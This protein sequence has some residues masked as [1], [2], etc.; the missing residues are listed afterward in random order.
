MT[1]WTYLDYT[2]YGTTAATTVLDAYGLAGTFAAQS[3]INVAFILP[4]A[5]DPTPFLTSDWGARQGTLAAL[6]GSGTLWSIYGAS[7]TAYDALQVFLGGHGTVLGNAAGSDGYISS[8]ES[9]TVWATLTPAQFAAVFGAALL[10]SD[11]A[12]GFQYWNG[13]LNVPAG[14]AGVWFDTAPWYGPTP[15]AGNLAGNASVVPAQGPLSIGNELAPGGIQPGFLEANHYAGDIADWFYNFPLAGIEAPT[16]TVGLLEPLVGDAVAAGYSFQAGYNSFRVKAGISTPGQYYVVAPG[17]QSVTGDTGE[18]SLD[19][20]V[21]SSANPNS[22]LG[23]YVGSG[24]NGFAHSNVFTAYQSA[25]FDHIHAPP[26]LSS[27]FSIVPQSAPGSPFAYAVQQLFIDAA[28]ANMTVVVADNDWGSSW[29]FGNGLAN[30]AINVSSPYALLVG[31]TSLTP[32]SDAARD[33]SI[34]S[35]PTL[36]DSLLSKAMAGDLATVWLLIEGGLTRLP[37]AV[38]PEAAP[39]TT[40][41]EAVWNVYALTGSVL[42]PGVQEAAAGDG[43]VDTTQPT[44]WYQTLFGLVPASA[45]PGGGTGRGAPDVAADSGG[46]LFYITPSQNLDGTIAGDGTS[47]AT[48]LWA[49]LVSQFDTIFHDQGLP[50]LGFMNDLLYQADAIAPGSFNDIVFG[51]NITS[52]RLG[53]PIT[54]PDEANGTV[55]QVTLTGLGYHAGHGYDLATGLGTP[56]GTLLARA[57]TAIAHHQVSF[58]A[59]PDLMESD[60]HGGWTSGADQTVLF[61]T[62]SAAPMQVGVTAGADAFGFL[63]APSAGFAWSM[64]LA[65]QSLQA[66]FDPRL[67]RLYDK[68]AQGGLAQTSVEAGGSFAVSVDGTATHAIQ[69]SLSSAFGFADFTTAGG[70]VRVARA[71]AVAETAGAQND[72]LAIVRIRQNGE[73]SLSLSFY[74]VDDLNGTIDGLHPGEA[75]YAAALQGRTYQTTAGGTSI[76]GP[77]YGNYT[78]TA[79]QHVNAGDLVAMQLVN[80][81]TGGTYSA[82]AEANEVVNGQHVGHLWNYGLNTWGWEDL[83][84]GGDRDFNDLIVGLDFTSASGHGWLV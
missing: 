21:V 37:S 15:A 84:G 64:Q 9:R 51:N 6:N 13:G 14:V 16:T 18:R 20:G 53:G 80:N 47:A 7:Q 8:P 49:S 48:P 70:D 52:Y 59:L 10:Q 61:Q 76:N 41:L 62:M 38:S 39:A 28:L 42:H 66:D 75:G 73:D 77:G 32:L 56:N 30:Q 22:P 78:Q 3:S 50:R 65:Q 57:L 72:Q 27:S 44:P 12:G 5:N 24:I 4:R 33:G 60:S 17:G 58:A 63:G 19:V 83:A 29:S 55:M 81:S 40:F 36:S 68:Q 31:G 1:S 45:N 35:L 23:L 25:F 2:S 82:F 34:A 46:N 26:V 79:L 11:P 43:G 54:T 74:R 71:V 67:V 69:G